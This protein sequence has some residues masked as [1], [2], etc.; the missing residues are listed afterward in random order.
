MSSL[1][2]KLTGKAPF[3]EDD[4]MPKDKS[5][6]KADKPKKAKPGRQRASNMVEKKKDRSHL[7]VILKWAIPIFICIG[8]VIGSRFADGF[9][10]NDNRAEIAAKLSEHQANLN[11][12][13]QKTD[14]IKALQQQQQE[15]KDRMVSADGRHDEDDAIAIAEFTKYMTWSTGAAYNNLKDAAEHAHGVNSPM[16]RCL[17][18]EQWNRYDPDTQNLI[19]YIDQEGLNL[20]YEGMKAYRTGSSAETGSVFY[21]AIITATRSLPGA[22]AQRLMFY[23][24]YTIKNK[25]FELTDMF[26]LDSMEVLG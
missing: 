15:D 22:K 23:A 17:F 1:F 11:K 9:I 19:Q 14:G 7:I 2:D 4:D 10:N 6:A 25:S 24:E 3:R 12:I 18:P 20:A 21:S 13:Q 26:M 8:L 16:V 5:E